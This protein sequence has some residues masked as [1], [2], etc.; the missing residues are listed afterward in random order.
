[1]IEKPILDLLN[2]G[3]DTELEVVPDGSR[4]IV[5]PVRSTA[6]KE[7]HQRRVG[8]STKKVIARHRELS[9]RSVR[10][11]SG[12]GLRGRRDCGDVDRRF[13]AGNDAAVQFAFPSLTGIAAATAAGFLIGGLWFSPVLFAEAW[14]RELRAT[15]APKSRT[16]GAILALPTVFVVAC[17]LGMIVR[18]AGATTAPE[19]MAVGALVWVAF[20]FAVHVPAAYLEGAPRRFLIDAGHKLVLYVVMGAILAL[21]A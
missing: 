18:A 1:V 2:I 19:G 4:I 15:D 5:E 8:T 17:V 13:P 3:R 20:A 12:S 21:W 14:L 7:A 16:M 6:E 11:R 10:K 9:A